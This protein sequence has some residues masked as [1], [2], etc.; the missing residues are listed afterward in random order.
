MD[1]D[2]TLFF[3]LALITALVV[4][5]KPLLF[6]PL[7]E[8]LETRAQQTLGARREVKH[9]ERLSHVDRDAYTSRILTAR[10]DAAKTREVLRQEGRDTARH[11]LDTARTELSRLMQA[12]RETVAAAERQTAADLG[13]HVKSLGAQVAKKILGTT[14][15]S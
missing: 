6:R 4:V 10:R 14:G 12:G 13:Q 7:L 1:L 3:Q 11:R 15:V 2:I 5:M 8:V 9:M